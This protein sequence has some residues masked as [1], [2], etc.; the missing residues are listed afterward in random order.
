[1]SDY[2]SDENDHNQSMNKKAYKSREYLSDDEKTSKY[3]NSSSQN[4]LRAQNG[5]RN[6]SMNNPDRVYKPRSLVSN[7]Q[8]RLP[9]M[10]KTI[11][12][13]RNGDPFYRGH[14]FVISTRRYRYFDVFMDDISDTLNA[15]F[16]AI[17]KIY[18]VD[19][20]VLDNLDTFEDGLIY[21]AAG[22]EKF[23][24]LK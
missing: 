7:S 14:K 11:R 20:Q 8:E 10:G 12:L 4:Y 3:N 13:L 6:T 1:M 17:R 21:V 2:I 18:T 5:T 9:E 23:I 19:G 22:T 16:G 15:N 24:R